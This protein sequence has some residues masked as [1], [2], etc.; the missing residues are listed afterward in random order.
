[1]NT[2]KAILDAGRSNGE[3]PEETLKKLFSVPNMYNDMGLAFVWVSYKTKCGRD[4]TGATF[5]HE[6]ALVNFSH[7][8]SRHHT[9]ALDIYL[10]DFISEH[11]PQEKGKPNL[12]AKARSSA[13]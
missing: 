9:G 7:T 12:S 13:M 3:T 11:W 8:V 2:H 4:V 1:M 6:D 5:V 10:T